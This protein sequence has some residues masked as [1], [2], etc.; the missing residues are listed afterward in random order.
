MPVYTLTLPHR[1]ALEQS[2]FTDTPL[3]SP[4]SVS[5]VPPFRPKLSERRATPAKLVYRGGHL[6]STVEVVTTF[7]GDAWKQQPQ[8]DLGQ[9][10]GQFFEFILS[11]QLIDRLAEYG[12][13]GQPI[14]H[15]TLVGAALISMQLGAQ[16]SDAQIQQLLQ[17]LISNNP[18][19]PQPA[20]NRLYFLYFPPN[21]EV[22]S[23]NDRS[24][25]Q[26]C[27][28]HSAMQG[29]IYYAV[30]PFPCEGG[31]TGGLSL[32]DALTSVTSHELCEAITD[33]FPGQ[34]WYDDANGEIGD[35]CAWQQTK[36]GD[37]TVQ[38]E[39]SNQS[40]ACL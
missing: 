17:Q 25:Q 37:Y 21:V 30:M 34:G 27:G 5:I 1:Q 28:Y 18:T 29:N 6:L 20:P 7:W 24:C 14:S 16:I 31:C 39:W 23:G 11:S 2:G 32:L 40:N 9:R 10:I 33:P 26:Y 15:G 12:V 38:K 36:V 22:A 4:G 13:D 35:I 3:K 8:S 19:F